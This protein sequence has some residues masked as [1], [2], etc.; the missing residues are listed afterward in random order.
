MAGR[1]VSRSEGVYLLEIDPHKP[2]EFH[3]RLCNAT[4]HWSEVLLKIDGLTIGKY[5]IDVSM[6]TIPMCPSS[7]KNAAPYARKFAELGR[8]TVRA[9]FT[10]YDGTVEVDKIELV[11]V[12]KKA[13]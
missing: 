10:R 7:M 13:R 9:V 8:H 3:L 5:D 11:S 1:S 6:T 4:G 2:E 12:S